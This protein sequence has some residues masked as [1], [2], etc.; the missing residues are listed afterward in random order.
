MLTL[1]AGVLH[2]A[3]IYFS[4]FLQEESEVKNT[5][6]SNKGSYAKVSLSGGLGSRTLKQN[7]A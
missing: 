7:P 1:G 2:P 6:D 3:G 5:S 4:K